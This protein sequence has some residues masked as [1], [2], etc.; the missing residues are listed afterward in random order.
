MN[1]L[2]ME[3][4]CHHNKKKMTSHQKKQLLYLCQNK[5]NKTNY[6]Y[7]WIGNER[8][9]KGIDLIMKILHNSTVLVIK[10]QY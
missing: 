5:N 8:E 10:W 7:I 9:Y 4:K 2:R 1:K 6:N 3:L